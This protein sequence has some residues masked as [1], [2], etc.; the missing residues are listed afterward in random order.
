VLSFNQT[1]GTVSFVFIPLLRPSPSS[2]L[3]LETDC[4]G[5][6]SF[7]QE[8]DPD[9]WKVFPSIEIRGI[10][11]ESRPVSVT[12][13]FALATPLCYTRG[14]VVPCHLAVQC[15]D[16]QALDLFS[17]EGAPVVRLRKKVKFRIPVGSE[18]GG[19]LPG[20]EDRIPISIAVWKLAQERFSGGVSGSQRGLY[21]ELDLPGYLVPS[22]KFGDFG[23]KYVVD[24]HPF[25]VT[26]FVPLSDNRLFRTETA[27]AS[28]FADGLRPR[29]YVPPGYISDRQGQRLL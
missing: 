19:H 11:F 23:V 14:S 15:D 13:T 29:A 9:G 27:V 28:A 20:A 24:I 3:R 17:S 25:D 4:E 10:L 5:A 8:V 1:R 7:G 22:F 16:K 18:S 2:L 26:G 6:H 12:V 21:G